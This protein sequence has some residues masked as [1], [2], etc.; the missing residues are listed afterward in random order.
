MPTP[1][2]T[3]QTRGLNKKFFGVLLSAIFPTWGAE[4]D[5]SV[6]L[7][8]QGREDR[9]LGFDSRWDERLYS[10]PKQVDLQWGSPSLLSSG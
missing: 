4:A 3:T 2:P 8:G 5:D 9:E 6:Q 7:L 10:S 1:K